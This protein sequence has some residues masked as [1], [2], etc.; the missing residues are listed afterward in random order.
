LQRGIHDRSY[1]AKLKGVDLFAGCSPDEIDRIAS[2]TTEIDVEAGRVLCVE[3]KPGEEFFVIAD[4]EAR[5]TRGGEEIARLGGG[6]FFGEMALLDGGARVATVT[7][8][9]PMK[10]LVLNRSEFRSLVE[11]STMID[12]RILEAI[13]LR[14]RRLADSST[15]SHSVGI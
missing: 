5:V 4:G 11:V 8:V 3:G 14:A 1:L 6:G 7:A 10:L 15:P 12:R 13:G 2:L 9:T